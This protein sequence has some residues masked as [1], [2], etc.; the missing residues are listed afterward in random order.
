MVNYFTLKKFKI[1]EK[2]KTNLIS[3]FQKL[4]V[5]VVVDYTYTMSALSLTMRTHADIDVD[6]MDIISV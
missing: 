1:K 3:Y 6:Y 5:H 4:H 2:S